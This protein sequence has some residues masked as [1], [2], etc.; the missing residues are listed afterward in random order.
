MGSEKN[1]QNT[2]NKIE[3]MVDNIQNSQVV[4]KTTNFASNIKDYI[5]DKLSTLGLNLKI[6]IIIGLLILIYILY[7]SF[8]EKIYIQKKE[9]FYVDGRYTYKEANHVCKS[10]N[11]RIATLKELYDNYKLGANWCKYGWLEAKIVAYPNQIKN[12]F[13]GK[14]GINGNYQ[15]NE[16]KNYGVVC[17]GIKPDVIMEK[18]I[19]EYKLEEV[20]DKILPFS[21]KYW[22]YNDLLADKNV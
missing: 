15:E 4:K 8:I 20:S 13:C 1:I 22:S 11:N 7:V 18:D 19:K 17:I 14:S 16:D 3:Y 21:D 9:V 10:L 5:S 6:L 12:S 2:T